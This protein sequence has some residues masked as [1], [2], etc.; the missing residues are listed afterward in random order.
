MRKG[1]LSFIIAIGA[2]VTGAGSLW[3]HHGTGISYDLNHT[4]L[5]LT[6]TVTEFKWANPHIRLFVDVKDASGKIVPWAFEGSSVIHWGEKGYNRNSVKVGQVVTVIAYPSKVPNTP[7]GVIAKVILP[8]GSD[9][10]HYQS[11]TPGGRGVD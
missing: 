2:L 3:A 5:R 11:E 1:M 4:P 9:T 10:L 7:N 8:D 6:G